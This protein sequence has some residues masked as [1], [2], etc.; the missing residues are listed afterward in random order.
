MLYR[1]L[2]GWVFWTGCRIT[3]CSHKDTLKLAFHYGKENGVGMPESLRKLCVMVR[4]GGAAFIRH[5]ER[6]TV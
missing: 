6:C 1:I 2:I 3:L 5:F 4:E